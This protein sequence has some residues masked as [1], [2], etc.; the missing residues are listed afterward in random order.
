MVLLIRRSLFSIGNLAVSPVLRNI[1]LISFQIWSEKKKGRTEG[2][3]KKDQRKI[4]PL[5]A[6]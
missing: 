6:Y 1:G 2:S 5:K 4:L 3:K